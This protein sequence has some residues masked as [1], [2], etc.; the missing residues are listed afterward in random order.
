MQLSVKNF[1]FVIQKKCDRSSVSSFYQINVKI[2]VLVNALKLILL[3]ECL[4]AGIS[5]PSNTY[6]CIKGCYVY[7]VQ[8]NLN[9]F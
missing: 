6:I 9:N 2:K 5:S 8:F 1:D 7:F 3:L 4:N